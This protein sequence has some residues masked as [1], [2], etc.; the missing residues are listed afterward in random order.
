MEGFEQWDVR[1][2]RGADYEFRFLANGMIRAVHVVRLSSDSE[3]CY[4]AHRYLEASPEFDGV[5]VRSGFQF[6]REI[7]CTGEVETERA[8]QRQLS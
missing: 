3:A 4:R 8:K 2:I 6:M 7:V 1:G 5:I